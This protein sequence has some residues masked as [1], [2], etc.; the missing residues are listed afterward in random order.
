VLGE[1]T[2]WK[3]VSWSVDVFLYFL[4][5]LTRLIPSVHGIWLNFY[6]FALNLII[7]VVVCLV[8]LCSLSIIAVIGVSVL[9][10]NPMWQHLPIIQSCA[11]ACHT[12]LVY[13]CRV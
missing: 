7:I 12:R 5:F 10:P 1:S 9:P 4:A 6:L 8:F 11:D 2:C 3:H 13:A